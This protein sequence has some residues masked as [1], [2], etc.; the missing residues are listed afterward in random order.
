M[1]CS[2]VPRPSA[3]I[4][5]GGKDSL[6]YTVAIAQLFTPKVGEWN[7]AR[8]YIIRITFKCGFSEGAFILFFCVGLPDIALKRE[9]LA[10]ALLLYE[11]EDVYF[12]LPRDCLGFP[13][14]TRCCLFRH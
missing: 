3:I 14:A 6:V 9:Q 12:W 4:S 8:Q 7:L 2:L 11:R 10:A 1:Q 13:L 5:M